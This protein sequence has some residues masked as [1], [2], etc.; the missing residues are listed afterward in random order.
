MIKISNRYSKIISEEKQTGPK[1]RR[2]EK[3]WLR[4]E[5]NETENG[6]KQ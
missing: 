4:A 1:A 3:I 5:T 2:K 6:K